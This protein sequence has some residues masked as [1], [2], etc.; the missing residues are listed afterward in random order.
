M[1]TYVKHKTRLSIEKNTLSPTGLYELVL[2]AVHVE[3][4]QI[5]PKCPGPLQLLSPL[6]SHDQHHETDAV[7]RKKR[8]KYDN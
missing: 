7:K 2:V 6:F 1:N 3:N 8:G 4:F 5:Q